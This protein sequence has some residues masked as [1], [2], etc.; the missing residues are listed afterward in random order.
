MSTEHPRK[1]VAVA[2]HEPIWG[3]GVRRL[4]EAEADVKVVAE[5]ASAGEAVRAVSQFRPD[6]LLLDLEIPPSGLEVLAQL[7]FAKVSVRTLLLAYTLDRKQMAEAFQ[8]GARGFVLKGSD[9]Q[10]LL[11]GVHSAIAGQYWLG[12]KPATER[13]L[14]LRNFTP[15]PQPRKS[16]RDYNLTP[17]EIEIIA[18]IAN[19]CS[20][21]DA[22]QKFS[23]TPRTVKHH[24]TNIYEK[25]G[26]SSRL[27]LALFAVNH[28]W[29]SYPGDAG[30][31]AELP[32]ECAEAS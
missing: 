26:L 28:H 10:V 8:A 6:L 12:E 2:V 22:S 21:S 9:T 14:A 5:A 32:Q 31:T 17:R 23:I 20:N 16:W 4:L 25:L 15:P 27:E 29:D 13:T 7:A 18:A 1:T 11:K 3:Y 24:L 30:C 19:G